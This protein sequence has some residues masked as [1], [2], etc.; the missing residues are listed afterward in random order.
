[1]FPKNGQTSKDFFPNYVLWTR[2]HCFTANDWPQAERQTMFLG[3]GKSYK[4]EKYLRKKVN[5]RMIFG[6]TGFI[7][8]Q[9]AMISRRALA[10]SRLNRELS[11]WDRTVVP[12]S[13]SFDLSFALSLEFLQEQQKVNVDDTGFSA[14]AVSRCLIIISPRSQVHPVWLNKYEWLGMILTGPL[15]RTV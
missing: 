4:G 5:I 14:C 12:S 11:C 6:C 15:G 3:V 7:I 9:K 8:K 1:M 2:K 10:A 13:S